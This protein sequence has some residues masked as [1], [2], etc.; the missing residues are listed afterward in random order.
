M[1]D[2][3]MFI[4]EKNNYE[5][6]YSEPFFVKK[7]K[8]LE[9]NYQHKVG[10][11]AIIDQLLRARKYFV[12]VSFSTRGKKNSSIFQINVENVAGGR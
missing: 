6:Y 12:L 9:F 7:K 1:L 10:T 8:H 3:K 4:N 2:K 5:K 11:W